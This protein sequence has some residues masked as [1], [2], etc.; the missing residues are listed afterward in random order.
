MRGAQGT[1]VKD[2]SEISGSVIIPRVLEPNER[3]GVMLNRKTIVG[4]GTG[5]NAGGAL[6]L[7]IDP[8]KAVVSL[9]T[10]G[11]VLTSFEHIIN[12][13]DPS[14]VV[15]EFSSASGTFLSLVCTLNGARILVA[16]AKMLRLEERPNAMTTL[17]LNV[18]PG[19]NELFV[20]PYF[21]GERTPNLPTAT[22]SMHYM[23]PENI[24]RAHVEALLCSMGQALNAIAKASEYKDDKI[25]KVLLIGG[26]AAN[27][28]V[29]EVAA[30]VFD[31]SEIELLEPDQYVARGA[32]VQA[33]WALEGVKPCWPLAMARKIKCHSVSSILSRF[34]KVQIQIYPDLFRA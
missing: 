7:E 26:A 20:L 31:A 11:A 5:D 19:S 33:A 2:Y 16:A 21:E 23:T 14:G 15:A 29:Q 10:S 6:R 3:A 1:D 27:R 17:V 24:I 13:G 34:E 8:G 28:A 22:A 32:A 4:A 25:H 30:T 9:G 12:D 18:R